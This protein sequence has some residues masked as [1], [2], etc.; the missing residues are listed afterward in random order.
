MGCGALARRARSCR[1][2]KEKN[3]KKLLGRIGISF[4]LRFLGGGGA[5]EV[6]KNFGPNPLFCRGLASPGIFFLIFSSFGFRPFWV[7]FFGRFWAH[8]GPP[9]VEKFSAQPFILQGFGFARDFFLNF[10]FLWFSAV[11]GPFFWAFL[12]AF[13]AAWG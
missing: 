13:W 8:F 1:R 9:G 4:F 5:P 10:L 6:L 7:E 12:G 11:F 3:A 2:L